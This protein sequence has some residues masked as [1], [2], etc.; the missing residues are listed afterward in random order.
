MMLNLAAR[1]G[2]GALPSRSTL[3]RVKDYPED[4]DRRQLLSSAAG[5]AI[6]ALAVPDVPTRAAASDVRAAADVTSRLQRLGRAQGGPPV[7]GALQAHAARTEA[8]LGSRQTDVV[9][10]QLAP[11]AAEAHSAASWE[12][13]DIGQHAAARDHARRAM[14]LAVG[15]A[16]LPRVLHRAG[17]TERHHTEANHALSLLQLAEVA[18]GRYSRD[19]EQL[20]A[21]IAADSAKLY[22][23]VGAVEQARNH[24][25][26]A[27]D[28]D[29]EDVQGVAAEAWAL[30]GDL[31]RAHELAA[32]AVSRR[33]S[34]TLRSA[35]IEHVTAATTLLRQGEVNV[36][37][38]HVEAAVTGV[39]ALSGS[40]RSAERL[41][42]LCVELVAV[43]D[44]AVDDLRRDVFALS[45]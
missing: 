26:A 4:V 21:T 1:R 34:G 11:V 42:P 31:D 45:A 18:R 9:R 30:L 10:R 14:S 41:R 37:I 5:A 39:R 19:D 38:P 17:R 22:A 6:A 12:C 23:E 8:L 24:L 20:R 28:S 29:T 43:R 25:A 40:V 3:A 33:D 13:C 32:G 7:V 16:A 35:V 2:S 27:A 36:A 15:S 44:S